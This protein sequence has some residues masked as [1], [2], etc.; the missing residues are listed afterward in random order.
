L[1]IAPLTPYQTVGMLLASILLL[2][3][4]STLILMPALVRVL[5]KWLFSERILQGQGGTRAGLSIASGVSV[6]GL[7]AISLPGYTS[8]DVQALLGIG[9]ASAMA[10][11][12]VFYVVWRLRSPADKP[13]VSPSL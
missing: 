12:A 10:V 13:Q 6:G 3:G 1:I 9:A 11:S 4:V 5:E 8:L 2:S 7:I